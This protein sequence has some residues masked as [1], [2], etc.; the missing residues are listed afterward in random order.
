M[1]S[2]VYILVYLVVFR[3]SARVSFDLDLRTTFLQTVRLFTGLRIIR[4]HGL[5]A[6]SPRTLL[7]E[8]IHRSYLDYYS[9]VWEGLDSE[10]SLKLQKLQN[11][12]ARNIA[13]SSYD[14]ISALCSKSLD[15]TGFLYAELKKCSRCTTI[16]HLS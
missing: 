11:R 7:N 1:R 2:F 14:S 13:F 8:P 10:F 6:E 16:W 3:L 12:A 15:G 5:K 4:K 9:V